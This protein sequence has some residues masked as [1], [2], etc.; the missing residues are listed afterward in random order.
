MNIAKELYGSRLLSRNRSQ[1]T[2]SCKISSGRK[3]RWQSQ[4]QHP[5][6]EAFQRSALSAK[7]NEQGCRTLKNAHH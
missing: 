4:E 2:S 7:I 1:H 3:L 6:M 5:F